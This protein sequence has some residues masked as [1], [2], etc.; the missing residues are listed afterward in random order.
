MACPLPPYYAT[1][2]SYA[3]RKALF[4]EDHCKIT[5]A[6]VYCIRKYD[7]VRNISHLRE[8]YM[9]HHF[10][11]TWLADDH[12]RQ[13]ADMDT[14]ADSRQCPSNTYNLWCPFA[15]AAPNDYLPDEAGLQHV[16]QLIHTLCD[17]NAQTS[18]LLQAWI[19]HMLQ[20]P[21]DVTHTFH[22]VLPDTEVE[23]KFRVLL[24]QLLKTGNHPRR[25]S[26]NTYSVRR[27]E[28]LNKFNF[29]FS[30][31]HLVTFCYFSVR[32]NRR[33]LRYLDKLK[34][35][36]N[37]LTVKEKYVHPYEVTS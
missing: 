22:P 33:I 4:E 25:W 19:G 14:Y 6:N 18:R 12:K 1:G 8:R 5:S 31:A 11:N 35:N 23:A 34:Q 24:G 16:L 13:Y 36:K 37:R 9:P 21:N 28:E 29:M 10:I 30:R 7:I 26:P 27:L 15:Y 32:D 20:Q 3:E 17:S 2:L